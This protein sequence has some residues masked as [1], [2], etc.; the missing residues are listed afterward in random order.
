MRKSNLILAFMALALIHGI[1][2][3]AAWA[4]TSGP[5]TTSTP[6]P[7]TTTDWVS[8]LTFP[9][10]NPALG[11]LTGVELNLTSTLSTLITITN[12]SDSPS[13]GNVTTQVQ[14]TVQDGGSNLTSPFSVYSSS[15]SYALGPGGTTDSG[16]LSGTGGSDITYI[17]PPNAW[18]SEFSGLGNITLSASTFTQTLLANTGGNTSAGQTT[19]ASL[20]GTVTYSYTA[21]PEP[22]TMALLGLGMVGLV[23]FGR[24]QRRSA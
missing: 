12:S 24:R 22:G 17:N 9:Q 15:Y 10:F 6:I 7:S 8:S 2:S 19:N 3:P 4:Q 11:T 18:I 21:I 16:I 1:L 14:V 5:F 23:A 13:S 20:S